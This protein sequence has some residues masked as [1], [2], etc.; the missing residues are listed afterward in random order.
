METTDSLD[1]LSAAALHLR[2]LLEDLH[3]AMRQL[4]P[5]TL[6]ETDP[7]TD[8]QAAALDREFF[9]L[10]R[11]ANDLLL[12]AQPLLPPT[13]DVD[14]VDLI[15]GL[16]SRA[17]DAARPAGLHLRFRCAS[18]SHLCALNRDVVEQLLYHLLALAMS[19]TARGGTVTTET[20]FFGGRVQIS[21]TGGVCKQSL[22]PPP[23]AEWVLMLCRC[24]AAS[25]DGLLIAESR[26]G[27]RCRFTV[28]FPDRQWGRA[29]AES[30]FDLCGGFNAT[31]T[32]LADVLP[33]EAFLLRSQG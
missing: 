11:L 19:A 8:R 15:G 20:R 29:A 1:P 30:S 26:R 12:S 16:C 31:L 4:L 6:R 5:P 2:S 10:L 7:E 18:A 22:P 33:A 32:A 21:V 17:G 3:L 25:Q 13:G 23:Q 27:E 24:M 28:S 9:R 14:I